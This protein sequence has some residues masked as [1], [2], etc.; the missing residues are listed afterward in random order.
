MES[1]C[2]EMLFASAKLYSNVQRTKQSKGYSIINV[3]HTKKLSYFHVKCYFFVKE[4]KAFYKSR[5][6]KYHLTEAGT[7]KMKHY[8]QSYKIIYEY[9]G[10]DTSQQRAQCYI[11]LE[12]N[13]NN[14]N[15]PHTNIC[16]HKID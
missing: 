1:A 3:H 10:I 12:C 11:R 5:T 13:H 8:F 2:L 4:L 6:Y 7:A 9:I 16:A 15:L 14:V